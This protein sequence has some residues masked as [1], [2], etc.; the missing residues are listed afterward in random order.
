MGA[1][2]QEVGRS[3]AQSQGPQVNGEGR[4]ELVS[5][6]RPGRVFCRGVTA[7]PRPRA[8]HCGAAVGRSWRF[9]FAVVGDQSRHLGVM[10][11]MMAR[12]RVGRVMP[13]HAGFVLDH[14]RSG[15][16]RRVRARQ[17]GGYREQY[18]QYEQQQPPGRGRPRFLLGGTVAVW[19]LHQARPLGSRI[20]QEQDSTVSQSS[21]DQDQGMGRSVGLGRLTGLD[22]KRNL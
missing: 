1:A 12:G 16:M 7:L 10:P 21:I 13:R 4:S 3:D 18:Q 6:Y 22:L 9:S 2:S 19:H 15:E 5:R 8:G 14:I 17:D 20:L 11:G